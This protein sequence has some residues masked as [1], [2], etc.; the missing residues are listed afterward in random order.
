MKALVFH[1]TG[2]I[3]YE[4]VE[5]PKP[6]ADEVLVKIKAVSICGSDLAGFRG[7]NT[8]R[9]PPLIMGHEFAGEVAALGDAV[10]TAK[11]GDK[12]GVY[13]NMFCGKCPACKIG[14]TNVCENRRIIGTTMMGGSYNGA[15]A[16]YVVAPAAKLLPLSGKR[17]F[18]EYALAEPLSTGLRATKLAGDLTGKSVAVIGCG[19]IGLLTI[20]CAKHF[21][22]KTIIAM[23]VLDK[24]LDM[25]KECGATDVLNAKEDFYAFTRKLTGGGG[26]DVVFDAVGN[27]TTVNLSSDVA[28]LGGKVVWV[29]LAQP[30]IEFEYKHAAIKELTFQSVY[31]YITEMEEGIQLIESGEIPAG[32]IITAEYPMSE[33][34]RLFQE[35]VSGNATDIK[36]IL[37][38]D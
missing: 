19:P 13:T 11:V 24:R 17:T 37:K 30:K 7:G 21:G 29:G 1:G 22:A 3:R 10:T 8:M 36:V 2:D 9:V 31:L 33:G 38:N 28:R 34:P 4:E 35:L 15:M 25:A 20:M 23:D 26:V 32:K 16:D 14:L 6:K 12:V 27:Q 5:T 18:A